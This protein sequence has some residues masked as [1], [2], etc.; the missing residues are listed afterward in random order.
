[1]ILS[2]YI[3]RILLNE[4]GVI[5]YGIYSLILGVVGFLSFLNSAMTVSTQ[6]YLSFYIGADQ[7]MKLKNVFYNSLLLHSLIAFIVVA[8]LEISKL[9]LFDGFLNIPVERL[10]AAK[11][12]FQCLVANT[13]ISIVFIPIDASIISNEELLFDSI[14][15]VLEVVLKL[16]G[17]LLIVN[18][19]GDKLILYAICVLSITFVSKITRYIFCLISFEECNSFSF[20]YYDKRLLKEMSSFAGWNTFGAL[21]GVAKNQGLAVIMNVFFGAVVNAAFGI[22]TQVGAQL[23]SFSTNMFKAVNP[24]IIKNEGSLNREAM[25]LLSLKATKFSFYMLSF[26]LIPLAFNIEYIFNLWLNDV[27]NHAIIFTLLFLTRALVNQLTTGLQSAMQATGNIKLYQTLVGGVSLLNLPISFLIYQ[28][29]YPAYYGLI[30]FIFIEFVCCLLR[31]IISKKIVGLS[32]RL[33]LNEVLYK[34]TPPFILTLSFCWIISFFF[35]EN[36]LKL[37][38]VVVFSS[39]IYS[40]SIYFWGFDE[41]EKT[42][43]NKIKTKLFRPRLFA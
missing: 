39:M 10:D 12:I 4:L 3:V 28:L 34:I 9:F 25:I 26:L 20:Q 24:Q 2:L 8:I 19:D 5:D 33:Y 40:I 38:T 21:C 7:I 35:S 41:N 32:Y 18:Y 13:L 15:S 36:L 11:F 22:A 16:V 14:I 27:P 43:L 1:M 30:S 23:L 42:H 29:G 17:C 6:R 31:L 37:I